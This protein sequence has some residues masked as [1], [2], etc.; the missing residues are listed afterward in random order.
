MRAARPRG[1]KES[2]SVIVLVAMVATVLFGVMGLAIE[3]AGFYSLKRK[4]QTAAD[5]GAKSGAIEIYKA[6]GNWDVEARRGATQNGY[7]G[8]VDGV[9]VT[10]PREGLAQLSEE[11]LGWLVPGLVADKVQALIRTL[12]KAVRR[13]L[14]PAPDIA[15]RIADKLPFAAGPLLPQVAAELTEQAG[16]PIRPEMFDVERLP[17]CEV[18]QGTVPGRSGTLAVQGQSA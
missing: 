1:R 3:V 9:T 17:R 13:N 12:P 18:V 11:R 6:S 7:T 4:M 5:A 10:V 14:G 15:R 2:G 16:E 8:G